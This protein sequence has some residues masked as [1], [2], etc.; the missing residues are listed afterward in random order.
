M[1][2]RRIWG[3]IA[4]GTPRWQRFLETPQCC[5]KPCL[6]QLPGAS[7]GWQDRTGDTKGSH[8]FG[9]AR[10]TPFS[11]HPFSLRGEGEAPFAEMLWACQPSPCT[12]CICKPICMKHN[13]SAPPERAPGKGLSKAGSGGDVR[14]GKHVAR[15]C[16]PAQE[17]NPTPP[18]G[19]FFFVSFSSCSPL[20]AGL[21]GKEHKGEV[22]G[23][24]R[25]SSQP[26]LGVGFVQTRG[27]LP[28]KGIFTPRCCPIYTQTYRWVYKSINTG[29]ASPPLVFT[30]LFKLLYP[31]IPLSIQLY[32]P[33][34]V[35]TDV[36]LYIHAHKKAPSTPQVVLGQIL[37]CSA[38]IPGDPKHVPD[39]PCCGSRGI[40]E[41]RGE[42]VPLSFTPAFGITEGFSAPLCSTSCSTSPKSHSHRG[43]GQLPARRTRPCSARSLR[44]DGMRGVPVLGETPPTP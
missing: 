30:A 36:Q 5:Y 21:G 24:G 8:R 35:H 18:V 1:E 34:S 16:F 14:R 38:C 29:L 27:Y 25:G 40:G 32:V 42:P 28:T 44:W 26:P 7:H 17:N 39:C 22:L 9:M 33:I 4:S 3:R 31:F 13:K 41:H 19:F 43:T 23:Q 37:G 12:S 11:P 15:G 6:G 2:I 20:G 10:I